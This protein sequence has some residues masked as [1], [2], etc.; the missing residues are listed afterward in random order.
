MEINIEQNCC[1]DN[2]PFMNDLCH[3][4]HSCIFLEYFP[5]THQ[6]YWPDEVYQL[7]F[8][9]I[10]IFISKTAE[11]I[12][13]KFQVRHDIKLKLQMISLVSVHVGVF[14]L[15]PLSMKILQQCSKRNHI[16]K[17]FLV[18][19]PTFSETEDSSGP[20]CPSHNYHNN[21]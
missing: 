6:S 18:R 19:G 2:M 1:S 9:N 12:K 14:N 20:N 11:T 16:Y 21:I 13:D 15:A 17:T 7:N 5:A 10:L 4:E 8:Y 3:C